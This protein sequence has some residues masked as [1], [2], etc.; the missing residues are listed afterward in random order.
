LQHVRM[1]EARDPYNTDSSFFADVT[2]CSSA[3]L[4]RVSK[5]RSFPR[6]PS[7]RLPGRRV[8]RPEAGR[9]AAAFRNCPAGTC[10]WQIKPV[11]LRERI[12]SET[13]ISKESDLQRTE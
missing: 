8:T 9:V 1:E 13:R 2:S 4:L 6:K 10:L 7:A 12:L 5:R 3:P 11:Q